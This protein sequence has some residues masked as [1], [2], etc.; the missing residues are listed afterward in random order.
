MLIGYYIEGYKLEKH[1][2]YIELLEAELSHVIKRDR[3]RNDTIGL[4]KI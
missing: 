4:Q 1:K 2:L 3:F